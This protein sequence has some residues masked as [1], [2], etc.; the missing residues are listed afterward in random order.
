MREE[1]GRQ[2]EGGKKKEKWEDRGELI[3]LRTHYCQQT[4]M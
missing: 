1:R 3:D 4:L 2:N